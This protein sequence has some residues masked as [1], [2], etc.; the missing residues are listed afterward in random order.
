MGR[1]ISNIIL[2][3]IMYLPKFLYFNLLLLHTKFSV[4]NTWNKSFTNALKEWI[5]DLNHMIYFS[6]LS[7]I[8]FSLFSSEKECARMSMVI[9]MV[10]IL[11]SAV[12][13]L[14]IIS[15]LTSFLKSTFSY[16]KFPLWVMVNLGSF[17]VWG[18]PAPKRN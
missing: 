12:E 6:V 16:L 17:F 7:L 1:V 2:S 13:K 15:L 14:I 5:N 8:M 3:I 18:D 4:W 10:F 11:L 9:W